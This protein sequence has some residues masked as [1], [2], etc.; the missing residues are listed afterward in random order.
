MISRVKVTNKGSLTIPVVEDSYINSGNSIFLDGYDLPMAIE[1]F[2]GYLK[3]GLV[4]EDASLTNSQYEQSAAEVVSTSSPV[5]LF[6]KSTFIELT[7]SDITLALAGPSFDGQR[8]TIV[9]ITANNHTA[10]IE[11]NSFVNFAT[12]ELTDDGA[13]FTVEALNDIWYLIQS[14]GAVNFS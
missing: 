9:M 3:N 5:S 7:D 14:T 12:A 6:N 2:D 8:K 13:S 10:T 1:L 4:F 11:S